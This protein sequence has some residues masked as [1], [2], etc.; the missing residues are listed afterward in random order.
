ME[1]RKDGKEERRKL[2]F[3]A[4]GLRGFLAPG[5]VGGRLELLGACCVETA[6]FF[7]DHFREMQY[8]LFGAVERGGGGLGEQ[9]KVAG[10]QKVYSEGYAKCTLEYTKCRGNTQNVPKFLHKIQRLY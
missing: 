4:P 2:D 1:R 10:I 3:L 5:G 6:Q 7:F 9:P 8:P